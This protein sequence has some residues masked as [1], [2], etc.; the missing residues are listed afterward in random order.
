LQNL[1]ARLKVLSGDDFEQ[2][3]SASVSNLANHGMR[4]V[5]SAVRAIFGD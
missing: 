2:I 5:D 3:Q 1:F 4:I